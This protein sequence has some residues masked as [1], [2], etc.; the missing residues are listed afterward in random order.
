MSA[1]FRWFQAFQ[2][3]CVCVSIPTAFN[4]IRIERYLKQDDKDENELTKHR[5]DSGAFSFESYMEA[6]RAHKRQQERKRR[7]LVWLNVVVL[8]SVAI[9]TVAGL[10]NPFLPIFCF[11]FVIL[12]TFCLSTALLCVISSQLK[13]IGD[14]LPNKKRVVVQMASTAFCLAQWLFL[15]YSQMKLYILADEGVDVWTWSH[16]T[17]AYAAWFITVYLLCFNG[18]NVC[19]AANTFIIMSSISIYIEKEKSAK[20][21]GR[22]ESIASTSS[23]FYFNK[24]D[25]LKEQMQLTLDEK[26]AEKK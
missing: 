19:C 14:M 21:P 16:V 15:A 5:T 20:E 1:L 18:V 25:E 9:T 12:A 4:S 11:C 22:R 8:S 26:G 10:W 6:L 23:S 13:K 17:D 3:L 2:Y 24:L 7:V